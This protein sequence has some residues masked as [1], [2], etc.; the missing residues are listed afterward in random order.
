MRLRLGALRTSLLTGRFVRTTVG[1]QFKG[2]NK[3][4][5]PFFFSSETKAK[6]MLGLERAG[7]DL[8]GRLLPVVASENGSLGFRFS[9]KRL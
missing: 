1:G 3:S 5:A 7:R 2:K 8:G 9:L 6:Q 4:V